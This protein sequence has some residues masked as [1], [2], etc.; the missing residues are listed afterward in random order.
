MG[1]YRVRDSRCPPDTPRYEGYPY[2]D[3]DLRAGHVAQVDCKRK[4]EEEDYQVEDPSS[5]L[6][7][8]LIIQHVPRMLGQFVQLEDGSN[9]NP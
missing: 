3:R 9:I 2:P 6:F 8:S 7:L 1:S 4:Y 5:T